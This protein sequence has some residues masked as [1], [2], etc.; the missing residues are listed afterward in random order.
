MDIEKRRLNLL[1]LREAATELDKRL[2]GYNA[3]SNRFNHV[4]VVEAEVQGAGKG[5]LY[6][7]VKPEA[8]ALLP[9]IQKTVQE[10]LQEKFGAPDIGNIEVICEKDRGMEMAD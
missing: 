6:V 9:D 10:Y 4:V 8:E 5:S 7:A 3:G 2:S 1:E